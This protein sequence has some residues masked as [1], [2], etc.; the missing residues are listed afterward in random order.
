MELGAL[1]LLHVRQ[2]DGSY[3][4]ERVLDTTHVV[5]REV[6]GWKIHRRL[7]SPLHDAPPASG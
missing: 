1:I 2:T 5:T 4:L 6:G 7:S 3:E